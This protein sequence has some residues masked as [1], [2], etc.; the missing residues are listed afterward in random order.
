MDILPGILHSGFGDILIILGDFAS[1]G[2]CKLLGSLVFGKPCDF[3]EEYP[4]MWEIEDKFNSNQFI[5]WLWP[6]D[7]PPSFLLTITRSLH[8]TVFPHLVLQQGLIS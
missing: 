5:W 2:K 8:T 6:A 4:P 7:W 1:L 3:F